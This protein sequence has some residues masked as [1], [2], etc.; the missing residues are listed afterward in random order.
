MGNRSRRGLNLPLVMAF[1]LL[2]MVLFLALQTSLRQS[3]YRLSEKKH[4][5]AAHWLAESGL[6][7]ATVRY[8]KGRY[9]VGQELR[10]PD[11]A[12]GYFVVTSRREGSKIVFESMGYAA[13]RKRRSSRKL[14]A[15]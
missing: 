5:Q 1:S 8:R 6:E 2:I 12:S 9:K 11:L 7:L 14:G 13:G 3:R 15:R 4:Q 10:S